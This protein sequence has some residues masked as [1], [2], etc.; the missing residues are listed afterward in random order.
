MTHNFVVNSAYDDLEI[1]DNYINDNENIFRLF[2]DEEQPYL[3]SFNSRDLNQYK[4]IACVSPDDNVRVLFLKA[5]LSNI[6]YDKL[7]IMDPYEDEA[8]RFHNEFPDAEFYLPDGDI[9]DDVIVEQSEDNCRTVVVL[10]NLV[11]SYSHTINSSGWFR[12]LMESPVTVILLLPFPRCGSMSYFVG[13]SMELVFLFEGVQTRAI[14]D[15]YWGPSIAHYNWSYE[16]FESVYTSE[17]EPDQFVHTVTNSIPSLLLNYP[18]RTVE[19]FD[20]PNNA[21]NYDEFVLS[22]DEEINFTNNERQLSDIVEELVHVLNERNHPTVL[23]SMYDLFDYA[24][25]SCLRGLI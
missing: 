17:T 1:D 15:T 4:N 25:C 22:S 6:K 11:G 9:A 14:Y 18:R 13:T 16:G 5:M 20:I 3:T 23:E 8:H 24:F 7:I 10:D 12:S 2:A 19:T 21:I